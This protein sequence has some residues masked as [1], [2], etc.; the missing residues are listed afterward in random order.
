M[1]QVRPLDFMHTWNSS[2]KARLN[3]VSCKHSLVVSKRLIMDDNG[4][5]AAGLFISHTM[6]LTITVVYRYAVQMQD[7]IYI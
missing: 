2:S 3:R 1:D 6:N 5:S 4:P 7:M